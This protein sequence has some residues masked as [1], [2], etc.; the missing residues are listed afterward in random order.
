L[1]KVE[2]LPQQQ[3]GQATEQPDP[4]ITTLEFNKFAEGD[5]AFVAGGVGVDGTIS[6]KAS[7]TAVA[8]FRAIFGNINVGTTNNYSIAAAIEG[9]AGG[10]TT[11]VDP[12]VQNPLPVSGPGGPLPVFV[13]ITAPATPATATLRLTLTRQGLATNNKR[14]VAYRLTLR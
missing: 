8:E 4:T 6:V 5:A 12:V 1:N 14:S 9:A 11:R 13:D 2:S 10:W 3:V 7:T